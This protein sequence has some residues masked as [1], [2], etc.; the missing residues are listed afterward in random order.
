MGW[1]IALA[2]LFLLAILPLGVSA[3][4][5]S[6]GVNVRLR[7][8]DNVG[9]KSVPEVAAMIRADGEEPFKRGGMRYSFA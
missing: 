6:G 5:D 2:L 8:G 4:Y 7:N 9:L 1:I 3:R